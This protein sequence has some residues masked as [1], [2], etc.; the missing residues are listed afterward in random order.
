MDIPP[1][2][3]EAAREAPHAAPATAIMSSAAAAVFAL[4]ALGSGSSVS[5]LDVGA[6]SWGPLLAIGLLSTAVAI[7]A[8]YAGVRRIGGARAALISSIEPVY[9]IVMA[10]LLF[11]EHL[12][13]IQVAGGALVVFAVILAESG[14]LAPRPASDAIDGRTARD[15]P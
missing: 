4:L 12:T 8:F 14:Q 6:G 15:V 9:T 11:G 10:V 3:A 1:A 5:P 7:Q 2:D 13:P